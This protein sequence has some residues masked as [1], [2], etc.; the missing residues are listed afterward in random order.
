[1]KNNYSNYSPEEILEKAREL[2]HLLRQHPVA[3]HYFAL[4]REM[5]DNSEAQELLNR[6]VTYGRDL[7][8]KMARGEYSP[9]DN[10][11]AEIPADHKDLPL[12]KDFIN[13][14]KKY[15]LLVNSLMDKIQNPDSN[16]SYTDE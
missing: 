2:S 3:V 5:N 13:A 1:M 9:E 14:Q 4:L 12:V 7:N 16:T 15:L 11:A 10:M 6:L 8:Q